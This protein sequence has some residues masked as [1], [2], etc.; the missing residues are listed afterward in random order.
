MSLLLLQARINTTTTM[1]VSVVLLEL[2]K[3]Q[4]GC[5]KTKT[6][7]ALSQRESTRMNSILTSQTEPYDLSFSRSFQS[8]SHLPPSYESAMK[9]DL[10]NSM[11]LSLY[12]RKKILN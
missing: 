6:V 7:I 1:W 3:M 12:D 5:Y 10:N 4:I 2:L 11:T 9:A 8:L